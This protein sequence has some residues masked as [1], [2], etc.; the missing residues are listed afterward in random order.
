ME[1]LAQIACMATLLKRFLDFVVK[2]T[3]KFRKV[4][5]VFHKKLFKELETK[6]LPKFLTTVFKK[7]VYK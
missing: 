2:I 3:L 6:P 1:I 4:K 7:V 5:I